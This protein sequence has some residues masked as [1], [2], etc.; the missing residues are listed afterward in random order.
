LIAPTRCTFPRLVWR[1][2]QLAN[3]PARS[4][5]ALAYVADHYQ[6]AAQFGGVVLFQ[7]EP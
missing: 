1:P 3:D 7:P 6:P 4:F 2:D 5:P